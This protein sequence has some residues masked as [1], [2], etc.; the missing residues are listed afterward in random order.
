MQWR[1]YPYCIR[2][3]LALCCP[4]LTQHSCRTDVT[5]LCWCATLLPC[6]GAPGLYSSCAGTCRSVLGLLLG[7]RAKHY[8]SGEVVGEVLILGPSPRCEASGVYNKFALKPGQWTDDTSMGLCMADSLLAPHAGAPARRR[9]VGRGRSRHS[10]P[11]VVGEAG[12]SHRRDMRSSPHICD[13]GVPGEADHG[14][15]SIWSNSRH[16]QSPCSYIWPTLA[17][18]RRFRARTWP[19]GRLLNAVAAALDPRRCLQVRWG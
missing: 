5:A 18:V 10:D 1:C 6:W 7:R 11:D 12:A 17:K 19:Q 8:P 9:M 15:E 2:R 13:V 3:G 14:T 4:R 16:L